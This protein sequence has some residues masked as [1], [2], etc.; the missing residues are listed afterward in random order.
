MS[1]LPHKSIVN[2]ILSAAAGSLLAAHSASAAPI[3]ITT[4]N[5]N[6]D[7]PG[8]DF[9]STFAAAD[10]LP[11]AEQ[12]SG[13]MDS[14]VSDA[15]FFKISSLTPGA[16]FSLAITYNDPLTQT[17]ASVTVRNDSY[18]DIGN[19]VFANDFS[20]TSTS[21]TITGT[22]PIS[23]NLIVDIQQN[24]ESTGASYSMNLSP[25]PE[26][27]TATVSLLGA[28]AVALAVR[29]RKKVS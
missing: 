23:G 17:N 6:N 28:A 3:I 24:A 5:E 9:S 20:F 29:S 21:G 1:T 15:D 12:V 16:L 22:V 26:P 10:I 11:N 2:S 13:D 27:A 7:I 25:I 4:Y 19:T 14:S 18:A 8:G